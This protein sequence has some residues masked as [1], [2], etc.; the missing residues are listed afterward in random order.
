MGRGEGDAEEEEANDDGTDPRKRGEFKYLRALAAFY[1]RLAWEPVEIHQTLEPLLG[2]FRKIKRRTRDGFVLTYM[3]QF[4]DDLLTKDR[5]CALWKMPNR[6]MLEDLDL[7]Q[8]RESP[9]GEELDE[10]DHSDVEEADKDE[11]DAMDAYKSGA[12]DTPNGEGDLE[13]S[14]SIESEQG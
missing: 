12:S 1:I 4:I 6:T 10:L 14:P 13:A 9:L 2:D 7:L 8:P 11:H 5:A 3:D